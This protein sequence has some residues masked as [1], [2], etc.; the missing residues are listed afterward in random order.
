MKKILWVIAHLI[1]IGTVVLSLCFGCGFSISQ[2]A[3]LNRRFWLPF[4]D[5]I[6]QT[7]RRLRSH[8]PE[9]RSFAG[10]TEPVVILTP[11]A[12]ARASY[13]MLGQTD[14]E[15]EEGGEGDSNEHLEMLPLDEV[16]QNIE[17]ARHQSS[18]TS[19]EKDELELLAAK[20]DLREGLIG[21]KERLISA[22]HCLQTFLQNATTPTFLSEARGWLACSCYHLGQYSEA[23]KIYLDEFKA[24]DSNFKSQSLEE[25]LRLVMRKARPT[26][27][28]HIGEYFDTPEHALFA[29]QM[30]SNPMSEGRDPQIMRQNGTLILS[31]MEKH[32]HLF[33]T[34]KNAEQLALAMMRVSL[35]MGDMDRLLRYAGEIPMSSK[36]GRSTDYCW[37]VGCAQ[38]LRKN[39]E[40]AAPPLKN[41][42]SA[43]DA[44]LLQQGKAAMA[45]I[46]V[47]QRL[48]RPLDS[49]DSALKWHRIRNQ[50]DQI[51]GKIWDE[52]E[53]S[54]DYT[55]SY[56]RNLSDEEPT[57]DNDLSPLMPFTDSAF[58][59][60]HLLDSSLTVEQLQ[61]Y[62]ETHPDSDPLVPYSLA[63]RWARLENYEHAAQLYGQAGAKTRQKRMLELKQLY[64]ATQ[65]SSLT[66]EETLQRRFAYAR[67]LSHHSCRVF[68]NDRIWDGFQTS[69][70]IT[71]PGI[72][73]SNDYFDPSNDWQQ[74]G[75]T[76]QERDQI[77][78]QQRRLQDE[79]EEYWRAYQIFNDIVKADGASPLG[80]QAARE[81]IR[82]LS[83]ISSRFGREDE[84][85]S[86]I[87]RLIE[88]LKSY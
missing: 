65:A 35:A 78:S 41:I 14:I 59:L 38:Y 85:K 58:D 23:I 62:L 47:Y 56:Q 75:L 34:K 28:A 21:D 57:G 82:C 73:V 43:S 55:N 11:L 72:D 6:Q 44:S 18:L 79:Q 80:K 12:Q 42:L 16:R 60:S 76:R 68:F 77:V 9:L 15:L 64:T 69:S 33:T 25:S 54:N 46:G 86:E 31:E 53:S 37:M 67:F 13:Q 7:T 19:T 2:R 83:L 45:L 27:A 70:F 4:S 51:M 36:T 63:V 1:L 61:K 66:K 24:P 10:Y 5:Y 52:S 8:E 22:Q 26:L 88:F 87:N 17:K 29:V 84:I 20:A 39:F 32:R 74:S 81:A 48:N 30:A 49:L 40:A 50:H 3:Y 71:N